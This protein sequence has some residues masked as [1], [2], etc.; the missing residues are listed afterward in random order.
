MRSADDDFGGF[1]GGLQRLAPAIADRHRIGAVEQHDPLGRAR[2]DGTG[3]APT[4]NVSNPD[5]ATFPA[6]KLTDIGGQFPAWG[7]DGTRVHWSVGN[8]HFVYDLDA[9]RAHE[10]SVAAAIRA[11]TAALGSPVAGPIP[12]RLAA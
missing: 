12:M 3:D 2:P 6:R 1:A 10:D 8:A 4:I 11:A 7:R 5:R 9:A